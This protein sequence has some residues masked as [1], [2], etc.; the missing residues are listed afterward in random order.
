MALT[1]RQKEIKGLQAEGLK[2]PEI[3]ERLGVSPNAIYQQ[4]A[5]MRKSG[6]SGG[7]SKTNARKGGSKATQKPAAAR[8]AR[9]AAPAQAKPARPLTPLQAI[10]ERRSEIEAEVKAATADLE[11]AEK[12]LEKARE[13]HTTVTTRFDEELAH[14]NGAEAVLKGEMVAKS[15]PK[16][17]GDAAS[18]AKAESAKTNGQASSSDAQTDVPESQAERE[19]S[20]EEF[21]RTIPPGEE[22]EAATATA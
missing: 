7:S 6:K 18:K 9:P 14:L 15:A 13:A 2:P 22:T 20:Q 1:A 10:R 19:A 4:L 8:P 16:A 5:R 12:A 21:D 11:A 3:A 17:K